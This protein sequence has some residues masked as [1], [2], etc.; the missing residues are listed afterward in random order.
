MSARLCTLQWYLKLDL[1]ATTYEAHPSASLG[2]RSKFLTSAG[3]RR[4]PGF[5][6][7]LWMDADGLGVV[8]WVNGLGVGREK[9]KLR[10]SSTFWDMK[11]RMS[12]LLYVVKRSRVGGRPR[13]QF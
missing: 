2:C 7:P 11:N 5:L 12:E 3:E 9:K 13:I 10:L 6:N 1:E 8:P 4:P